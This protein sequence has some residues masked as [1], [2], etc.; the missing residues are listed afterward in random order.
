[1]EFESGDALIQVQLRVYCRIISHL[2]VIPL[3]HVFA[4]FM[5]QKS[6]AYVTDVIHATAC[7]LR[8]FAF[9]ALL[10]FAFVWFSSH[11]HSSATYVHQPA[12]I[13]LPPPI[14]QVHRYTYPPPQ[15]FKIFQFNFF[16]FYINIVNIICKYF[17]TILC[18]VVVWFFVISSRD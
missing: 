1:M 7:C 18:M 6:F 2:H 12:S 11:I 10:M 8:A 3:L 16:L 14:L 13:Y 4:V 15:F 17:F 5:F 9:I